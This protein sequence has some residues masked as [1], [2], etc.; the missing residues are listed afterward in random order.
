MGSVQ[1]AL[2]RLDRVVGVV[3][4]KK[5]GSNK[6]FQVWCLEGEDLNAALV[7]QVD[8]LTGFDCVVQPEV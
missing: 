8:A 5:S 1:K 2:M 3:S 4:E 7:E 6:T